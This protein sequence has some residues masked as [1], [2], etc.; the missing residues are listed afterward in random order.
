MVDTTAVEHN[1]RIL[2]ETAD[3]AG[4]TI[5]LALKAFA[6]PAVFGLVR[7][8]LHGVCAS[9]PYEAHLGQTEIG[10]QVHTYG[11]AYSHADLQTVLQVSDHLS[12]NSLAQWARFRKDGLR[13]QGTR[14]NLKFGLRV[15][16]EFS[17]GDT[18]LYDPCA[19]YSRLGTTAAQLHHDTV[20]YPQAW[21]GI[22]GIHLHTLCENDSSALEQTLVALE[23]RFGDVLRRPE[24]SWLNLGGGHHITKPDYDREHLVRLIHDVKE[25]YHVEVILE[26][27]EAVAI[28]TGV[29]VASVLDLPVNGMNLAILDTSATAHMPDTLEMPYRPEVWGSSPPGAAHHLYRLGGGTCLAGDVIGDYAFADSLSVGDRLVFDDMSHYTMVKTTTFNGIPLPAIATWNSHTRTGTV[30]RHGSYTDF[31]DRL[32]AT[33]SSGDTY[34]F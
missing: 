13:A 31:R 5:L 24:I 2:R 6:L 29:L 14:R 23:E 10:G 32:G 27:G 3:R 11:P 20:Q 17:V 7:R 12:F 33:P 9:G 34:E 25:R 26:P 30:V 4:A 15:N 19:P 1:L 18:P 8:Y 22:S 21:S 28:H 16:P